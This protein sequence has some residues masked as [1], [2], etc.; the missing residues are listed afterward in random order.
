[1]DSYTQEEKINKRS[2]EIIN[3]QNKRIKESNDKK[4]LINIESKFIDS[5]EDDNNKLRERMNKLRSQ[6]N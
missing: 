6:C 4:L 2:I 5:N 3:T 1:M